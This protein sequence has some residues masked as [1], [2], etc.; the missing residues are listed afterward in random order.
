MW[1][2]RVASCFV[3]PQV[4]FAKL[5]LEGKIEGFV[6]PIIVFE[7]GSSPKAGIFGIKSLGHIDN[8]FFG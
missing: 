3:G 8:G 2:L 7:Y 6:L 4:A 5:V 1:K